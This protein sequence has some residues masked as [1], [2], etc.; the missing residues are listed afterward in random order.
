[1]H[2][3]L[4]SLVFFTHEYARSTKSNVIK[5]NSISKI[6]NHFHCTSAFFIL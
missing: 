2:N 1:M 4:S 3:Y 5:Y 6:V